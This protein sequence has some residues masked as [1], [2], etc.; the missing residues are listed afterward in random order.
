MT[1][2]ITIGALVFMG[3]CILA[4]KLEVYNFFKGASAAV[5]YLLCIA[6]SGCLFLAPYISKTITS[7]VPAT[8]I[9]NDGHTATVAISTNDSEK[10]SGIHEVPS[11]DFP[12]LEPNDEV[13]LD[14]KRSNSLYTAFVFEFSQPQN[15]IIDMKIKSHDINWFKKGFRYAKFYLSGKSTATQW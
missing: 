7:Y 3:L 12:T 6:A 2:Q 4:W 10:F 11:R 1:D 14:I 8:V 9:S 13:T 5:L 15:T